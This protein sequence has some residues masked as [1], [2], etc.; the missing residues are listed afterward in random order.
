MYNYIDTCYYK[1]N[2]IPCLFHNFNVVFVAKV[3]L[4]VRVDEV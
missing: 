4:Q 2:L 3:I 1:I